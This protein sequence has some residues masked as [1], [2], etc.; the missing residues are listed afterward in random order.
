MPTANLS[1]AT[2]HYIEQGSGPVLLLI[3]GF[4]IDRTMWDDAIPL[5]AERWRMIAPDMRGFGQSLWPAGDAPQ[6]V[7]DISQGRASI[8]IADYADDLA[9]LIQAIGIKQPITL[10]GLSMGGYVAFQ[11][12]LR[13]AQLL[14]ALIL[15][16]TR[17]AADS[18]EAAAA[19]Q[20]TAERVMR[21]GPVFLAESMIPKL[22]WSQSIENK[23]ACV[24]QTKDVILRTDRR[25]IAAASLAMMLRSDVTAKLS[26][27][28]FPTLTI[29]GEHDAISLVAEMQT[30]SKLIPQNQFH[31]ITNAGHM[32][33]AEQ[34]VLFANAVNDF[35]QR[36][37][38]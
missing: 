34:P 28:S 30:W 33:P 5:L 22:F 9:E 21:E 8:S 24:E 20:T 3:H 1:R 7:E 29:C 13:H 15:C 10:C 37:I 27:F 16:D 11:F 12:A 19:R 36:V 6:S 26:A 23:L 38:N 18:P 35:Q 14:R 2:I 31:K 32:S 25:A 4:P 17:A